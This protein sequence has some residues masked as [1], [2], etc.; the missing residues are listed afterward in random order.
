MKSISSNLPN[1]TSEPKG[2]RAAEACALFLPWSFL[3]FSQYVVLGVVGL[4]V[5]GLMF[6]FREP[7]FFWRGGINLFLL[8]ISVAGLA[9]L[10]SFLF[11]CIVAYVYEH[12]VAEVTFRGVPC[13]GE[14]GGTEDPD[15]SSNDTFQPYNDLHWWDSKGVKTE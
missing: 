14:V 10:I 4:C 12:R 11:L 6:W 5:V 9:P 8:L 7:G 2:F 3:Y 15:D 13:D 1:R